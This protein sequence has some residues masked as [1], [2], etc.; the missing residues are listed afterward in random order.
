MSLLIKSGD[1]DLLSALIK[2]LFIEDW[3]LRIF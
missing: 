1:K 3:I 2:I